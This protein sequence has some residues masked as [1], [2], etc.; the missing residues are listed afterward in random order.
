M[1]ALWGVVR[2]M[3]I[4]LAGGVSGNLNPVWK[5]I[6]KGKGWDESIASFLGRSRESALDPVPDG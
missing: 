4:F 1:S 2:T 3:K 6:A 5:M